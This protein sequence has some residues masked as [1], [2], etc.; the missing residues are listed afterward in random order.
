M[1]KVEVKERMGNLPLSGK[2]DWRRAIPGLLVSAVSLAVVF[3][4]A[5][6]Q[7][8][9][10]ALRLA[11]YRLVALGVLL[12]LVWLVIRSFAWRTLLREKAAYRDV[13]LAVNEGYLL[14]NVLPFRLGEVGRSYLLSRKSGQLDFWQVLSSIVIERVLDLFMAVGLLLATLPYVVGAGWA[15]Q[16]AYGAG[17]IV[18]LGFA[19]LYLM[20]RFRDRAVNFFER[21]GSRW[22]FLDRLGGGAVPAFLSG[23]EVLTDGARFMRVLGWISL[24]WFVSILQYIVYIAAFFS[25]SKLLWATFSLGV[26]AL[27]IAAPSSPGA[28]GVLELSLVG[29]LSLFKLD[30]S[31]ALAFAFSLHFFQ[32]LVTGLIGVYALSQEG[33]SF[34]DLYRRV[35][36]IQPDTKS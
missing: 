21:L 6:V 31:V 7:Q 14:N 22:S 15:R 29:A 26:A 17:A 35:R 19:S 12:T 10:S 32:Y 16:A 2:S 11:D 24:N 1:E 36:Q 27:G 20:A 33:E 28:V 5:D 13:F 8:L 25:S 18:V 30:A 34:L 9:V 23:L 3:Y 4:F